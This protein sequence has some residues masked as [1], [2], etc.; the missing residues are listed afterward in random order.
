MTAVYSEYTDHVHLSP[1][2]NPP[3]DRAPTLYLEEEPPVLQKQLRSPLKGY[4]NA[5]DS[6][7]LVQEENGMLVYNTSGIYVGDG[8]VID[9][10]QQ[11]T[12]TRTAQ[13]QHK[14]N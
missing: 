14:E 2:L 4:L 6:T 10:P 7:I 5:R 9:K 1:R 8:F 12:K 11:Q 3:R 13:E